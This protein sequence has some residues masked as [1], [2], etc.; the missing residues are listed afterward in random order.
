MPM[1]NRSCFARTCVLL[2]VAYLKQWLIKHYVFPQAG[3]WAH[4]GQVF[5]L[6][7]FLEFIF[8]IGVTRFLV[9]VRLG[10]RLL[11]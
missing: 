6:S 3:R 1:D 8:L 5:P 9:V 2:F 4:C 10:V 11:F 7:H